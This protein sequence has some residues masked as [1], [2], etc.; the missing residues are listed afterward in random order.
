M[1]SI[2]YIALIVGTISLIVG[3]ISRLT[4]TPVGPAGIEA[5]RTASDRRHARSPRARG[6]YNTFASWQ[7]RNRPHGFQRESLERSSLL[8]RSYCLS[9]RFL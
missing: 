8:R 5:H 9:T 7:K 4:L 6:P 3:V 2:A 1:K